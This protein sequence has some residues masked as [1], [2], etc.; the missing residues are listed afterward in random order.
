MNVEQEA[1][2]GIESEDLGNAECQALGIFTI[3]ERPDSAIRGMTS[4]ELVRL[5]HASDLPLY[6][7]FAGQCLKLKD[8]E[9]LL[10]LAFHAR[11]ACQHRTLFSE[12]LS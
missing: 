8:R 1:T 2:A 7:V 6:R 4:D 3:A 10:Q 5:I 12:E 9:T 11:R